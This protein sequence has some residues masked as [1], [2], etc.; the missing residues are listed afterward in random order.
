[1]TTLTMFDS[2]TP[3]D[4]PMTGMDAVLAYVNGR[5]NTL[6][7]IRQRYPHLPILT[8]SVNSSGNA[9]CL[10]VENGDATPADVPGWLDRQKTLKKT[11]IQIIYTPASQI[12]A[13]RAHAGSR[14]YLLM[15]AH[16]GAGP[17]ICGPRTCGYPQAD[18]TQ[19]DDHGP[20]GEHY[21]RT[22]MSAA[23]FA[24]FGPKPVSPI[25]II[26]GKIIHIIRPVN[27]N[28]HNENT[29]KPWGGFPLPAT[30]WYGLDDGT[31]HSHSGKIVAN[32]RA[33]RQIQREVGAK[34]D[35][36]YGPMT[37]RAVV[38]YQHRRRIVPADGT[39]HVHTWDDMTRNN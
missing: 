2:V 3:A 16:Y 12:S 6:A 30:D 19:W 14:R 10:D 27:H 5:Y 38:A 28:T 34:D 37:A 17:H 33:I 26:I 7:A 8:C 21:D 35:G 15:S 20:H 1:M 25:P 9:Q 32:Q 22:L 36:E 13:V 11:E 23:F 18:A 24:A 4:I 31:P 39:V 29:D